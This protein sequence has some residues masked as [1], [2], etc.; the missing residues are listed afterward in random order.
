MSSCCASI[1]RWVDAFGPGVLERLGRVTLE[2]AGLEGLRLGEIVRGKKEWGI[3]PELDYKDGLFHVVVLCSP[4]PL[5]GTN[6][7]FERCP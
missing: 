5:F 3:V 7:P 4:D 1:Q 6:P 2:I